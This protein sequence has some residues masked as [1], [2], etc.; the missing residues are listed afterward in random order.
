M[1]S[2]STQ[3]PVGEDANDL[4]EFDLHKF[5]YHGRAPNLIDKFLIIGYDPKVL[6]KTLPALVEKKY[7]D[8]V[9]TMKPDTIVIEEKCEERP[10][11][12]NEICYDYNK[13][14]LDNDMIL[15]LLFPDAPTLYLMRPN[16]EQK[17]MNIGTRGITFS[18]SPQD[19]NNSKKSYNGFGF[20]FYEPEKFPNMIVS[21][22]K[23]FCILS[24]YPYFSA[25]NN[26]CTKIYQ[27]FKSDISYSLESILYNIVN[28]VPSPLH[29]SIELAIWKVAGLNNEYETTRKMTLTNNQLNS[30]RMSRMSSATIPQPKTMNKNEFITFPQLSGYPLFNFNLP[31][32]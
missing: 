29:Y 7:T 24:E 6:E 22:P 19:N 12:L 31:V 5:P 25:Y 17:V 23:I 13:E 11:V 9:S 14:L 18:L 4:Q 30:S 26:L 21:L 15:E 28:Y 2:Q 27:M 1:D 20:V 32:L 16:I 8:K 10:Q 3:S